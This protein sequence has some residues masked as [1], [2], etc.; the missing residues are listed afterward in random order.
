M[1]RLQLSLVAVFLLAFIVTACA[2]PSEE[3]VTPDRT[4]KVFMRDDN[5]YDPPEIE[6]SAGETVAFEVT[7]EGALVHELLIGDEDEQLRYAEQMEHGDHEGHGS[8]VPG[9]VVEPGKRE[10]FTYAVP[11]DKG[12]L[13][14]GCHQPGHYEAGM[15]GEL[16][17]RS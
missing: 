8:S 9:V 17:Y 11:P 10:I 14:F 4:V 2:R 15:R 3:S 7:N 6:V 5:T 13:Y 16:K 12:R 1:Q